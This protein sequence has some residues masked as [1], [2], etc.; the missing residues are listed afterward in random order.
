VGAGFARPENRTNGD[1]GGQTPPLQNAIVWN[2]Q[3]QSGRFVAN[4][5]YLVIVEATGISGRRFTY[6]A[7]IGINR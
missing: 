1:L 6:S 5:T 3:N 4:G 7:R 2:L